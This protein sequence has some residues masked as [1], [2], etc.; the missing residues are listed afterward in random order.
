M[1]VIPARAKLNL[2]LAVLGR[3][4]DGLH[5][6]ASILVHLDW[7][8]LAGV[9]EHDRPGV[10]LAVTGPEAGALPP[11]TAANL[12]TRAAAAALPPGRGADLWLHKRIPAEA[13]LGGGSADAAAV[14]RALGCADTAVA[15]ALGA[16]VPATLAG[17]TLRAGGAGEELRRLDAAALHLAVAVAGTSST[18]ATFAALSRAEHT[19][20]ARIDALERALAAGAEFD[21]LCG[22]DLEPAAL[23]ANPAL[24]DALQR[25]RAATPDR[26]W[27][28]TG[29][30]GAAFS[31]A[32]SAAEATTL[33]AA[34]R[35]ARLPARACRTVTAIPSPYNRGR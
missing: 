28:L 4:P 13:G 1:L 18:A 10:R 2:G 25:L 23:R 11:D 9:R 20:A 6:L 21:D 12:A 15:A 17:G 5:E 14:L 3:R 24:G 8:D 16:D 35:T 29:S 7:H 31:L 26:R 19:G 22:S 32:T 27:H 33:A 34:A 30:G